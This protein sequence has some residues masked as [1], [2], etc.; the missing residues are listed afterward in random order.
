M[1]TQGI[2]IYIDA[3]VAFLLDRL[4]VKGINKRPLLKKLG[5]NNLEQGLIDQ[6]NKR[7]SF[8]SKA[9]LILPYEEE[10]EKKI[11]QKIR[12]RI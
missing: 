10:L 6:L 7:L 8:Y 5:K 9:Q 4:N 3:D 2:T 11:V 1:N 12:T